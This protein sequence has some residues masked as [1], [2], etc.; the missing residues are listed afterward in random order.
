M[1]NQAVKILEDEFHRLQTPSAPKGVTAAPFVGNTS[2]DDNIA[3]AVKVALWHLGAPLC[4][5]VEAS[6][7]DARV[8]LTGTVDSIEQIG[9]IESAV[10]AVD[11]IAGITNF[12]E[13]ETKAATEDAPAA[14]APD[15]LARAQVTSQPM[16]FVT[17]YCSLEPASVT[18]AIG[19]GL[20]VL[21]GFIAE[22]AEPAPKEAIVIY[23]NRLPE[24]VIVEVGYPVSAGVA[25]RAAGE[26]KSGKTPGGSMLSIMPA[27]GLGGLLEAHDRLLEHARRA[28]LIPGKAVW[29]RFSAKR[30]RLGAERPCVSLYLP[31]EER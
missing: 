31:V 21:D 19:Q 12:V 2:I 20:H 17:R 5:R 9:A 16:L 7:A 26:V 15:N 24:T 10:F 14:V 25:K 29:Q 30:V 8:T 28:K 13:V 6:V 11:G 18:A 4:G 27:A 23:R 3:E 1:G 22:L